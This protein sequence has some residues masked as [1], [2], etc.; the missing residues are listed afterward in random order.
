M[1]EFANRAERGTIEEKV[2]LLKDS[3]DLSATIQIGPETAEKIRQGKP[4]RFEE[5]AGSERGRLRKGQRVGLCEGPGD[6]LAI[7]EAQMEEAP[8]TPPA[9]R[10]LRVFHP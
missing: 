7:A 1:E 8:G 10:I 2:L 6:L 3:V 5:L 4:L 9:L